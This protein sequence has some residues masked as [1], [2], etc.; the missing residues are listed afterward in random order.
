M[1][2]GKGVEPIASIRRTSTVLTAAWAV[3][4]WNATVSKLSVGDRGVAGG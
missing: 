2:F 1:H 3:C 4:G